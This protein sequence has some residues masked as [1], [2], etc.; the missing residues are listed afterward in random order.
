MDHGCI[1][2]TMETTCLLTCIGDI[3]VLLKTSTPSRQG[4]WFL[5]SG[6]VRQQWQS[7][8]TENACAYCKQPYAVKHCFGRKACR[9][10]CVLSHAAEVQFSV[11]ARHQRRQSQT[12]EIL[13]L[14]DSATEITGNLTAIASALRNDRNLYDANYDLIEEVSGRIKEL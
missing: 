8:V 5:D 14:G 6:F 11:L 4:V 10:A 13:N 12:M 9:C 3:A 7:L 1:F 2:R